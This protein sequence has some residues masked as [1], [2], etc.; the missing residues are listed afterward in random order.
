MKGA[1][2][3]SKQ[4]I[5]LSIALFLGLGGLVVIGHH[6]PHMLQSSIL[7]PA[8]GVATGFFVIYGRRVLPAITVGFLLGHITYALLV[9]GPVIPRT[10]LVD[11]SST[12]AALAAIGI[13]RTTIIRWNIHTNYHWT[14]LVRFIVAAFAAGALASTIGH[15]GITSFTDGGVTLRSWMHW[16]IGDTFGL[17]I[18]TPAVL[19]A[20][21]F[22]EK[23]LKRPVGELLVYASV[24]LASVFLLGDIAPSI[25]F[26]AHKFLY[27]PIAIFGAYYL[28]YR[29][30]P[31]GLLIFIVIIGLISPTLEV[32]T[33]Y[34]YLL[35]INGFLLFLTIVFFVFKYLF[36]TLMTHQRNTKHIE[37]RKIKLVRA[38]DD[39]FSLSSE[40]ITPT[41][42]YESISKKIFQMVF[43]MFDIFDYGSC[44]TIK[45][46]TVHF[47][48]TVGH[49]KDYLNTMGFNAKEFVQ[50]ID[51]PKHITNTRKWLEESVDDVDAFFKHV[52][53]YQESVLFSIKV[54]ESFYC[55]LSFD[56]KTGSKASVD[57]DILAYFKRLQTLLNGFFESQQLG[58]QAAQEKKQMI[59]ALLQ[60]IGLF[61]ERTHE[62]SED[63]AYLAKE[64]ATHYHFD[65]ATI[66]E[67]YWAGIVHDIGKIGI[68]KAI[69]NKPSTLT[70]KQYEAMKHHPSYGFELLKPSSNLAN[71]ALIV[72]DHHERYDGKGYPEELS[73]NDIPL[74]HYI[75]KISEDVA[76][77]ARTQ[78]YSPAM[79]TQSIKADLEGEA[80][81]AYPPDLVQA[82]IALIDNGLLSRFYA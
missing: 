30:L 46:D 19:T 34:Y 75:L 7:W 51:A 65:S 40:N 15:L 71:V 33:L 63:V 37:N 82:V 23:T 20:W 56:I 47:L 29:S 79:D 21:R 28:P 66:S 22:D 60:I 8:T 13:V 41:S 73:G 55:E 70:V 49:D 18:F 16:F 35:D 2:I 59:D 32:L 76:T 31:I 78:P 43:E 72:Y 68:D 69:V 77:M 81:G 62:H 52:L 54:S 64:I 3:L 5:A 14:N 6:F 48:E 12:I 74:S 44:M 57:S 25:N 27:L 53:P 26:H 67:L 11:V 1:I 24:V 36:H 39:F 42:D 4:D 50:G 38:M 58:E 80:R 45:D 10:L 9:N 61:D 17:L